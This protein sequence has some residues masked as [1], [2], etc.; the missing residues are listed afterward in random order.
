MLLMWNLSEVCLGVV[1]PW[2]DESK[3]IEM[4]NQISLFVLVFYPC[5]SARARLIR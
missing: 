3:V 4:N 2:G 1:V 5:C